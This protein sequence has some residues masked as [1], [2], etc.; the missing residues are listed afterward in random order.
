MLP[1]GFLFVVTM[2]LIVERWMAINAN[3]KIEQS[4]VDNVKD[5]IQQGNLK[6]AESLCRNQRNAAGRIFGT[7]H[8]PHRLSDQGYRNHHRKRQS[9]RVATHGG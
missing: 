9:D 1:L 8:G 2:V 7:R 5:F 3:G 6:S 4:F